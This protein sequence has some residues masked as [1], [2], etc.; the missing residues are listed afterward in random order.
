[1]KKQILLLT[2]FSCLLVVQHLHAAKSVWDGKKSDA[3]WYDDNA[4]EYHINSASQFKGFADL[5]SYNNCTFEG[6][7]IYLDCDIDLSSHPWSPIGLHSGKPFSGIFDGQNHSITNLLI[8]SNQFDYP[9][10]KDNVG[11][12]GYA[13]KA[14]IKNISVEGTLEIYSGRYIGGVAAYANRIENIYSDITITLYNSM[15]SSFIGTVVS[16]AT[17]AVKVYA[18]GEI[19]CSESYIGLTDGCYVGGIAGYCINMS[20]CSSDVELS[21]NRIGTSSGNI[22][23]ISGASGS[24]SNAIFTGIVSVGNYNCNSDQFIP[25]IGGVCG[26]LTNGDHLISAPEIM[27]Y[28]RGWAPGK[29]IITPKTSNA[30]ITNSYYVNT[31]AT[32]SESYGA[33]I[34]PENLKSGNPLPGFD[35]NLWEFTANEYPLLTSLKSLMPVPTYTVEYY[36]DGVL[37]QADE[38]K[39]G[40]TVVVPADPQ[41]EGYTFNGWGYIPPFISGNGWIVNGSFSINKYVITYMVDDEVFKTVTQEY[42]SYINPPTVFPL[43]QGYLFKWGEYPEKVPAH[44]VTIVGIYEEDTYEC[45]DLGLPSGLL[46]ATKNIGATCPEDNG[47]YFSWGETIIKESY[48]WGTYSHCSGSET[49]LTKYCYSS[50]FGNLDNKMFL[51]EDDDAATVNWGQTWRLPT[52]ADA[53]ELYNNCTWSLGSMNGVQGCYVTGP[54]GNSIFLPKA[55]YKQ[56]KT[57]F[58]NRQELF[59]LTSTLYHGGDAQPNYGLLIYCDDTSYGLA[60]EERDY[61][62]SARAVTNSDP[63]GITSQRFGNM[64]E[65][66]GVYDLQGKKLPIMKKGINIIRYKNGTVRKVLY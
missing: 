26:Q 29:G 24:I 61:G 51:D 8:N 16:Q 4:S 25:G 49:T 63:N 11:L 55:G 59:L 45:V 38:Y 10:M 46:W 6:K 33:S 48:Y 65:A 41:K 35:T 43:K 15:V 13:N 64:V 3:S 37:Y 20:E 34:T 60:Y 58:H 5:V 18:M 2:L 28:G 19:R 7:T 66:K 62:F 17:D 30:N 22:G 36:V 31:W 56:Y 53:M 42:N 1:M 9:D 47:Y 23:G 40:E 27:S 44:D 21:V 50:E 14:E 12:F 54:N 32:G 57:T 52:E 39:D